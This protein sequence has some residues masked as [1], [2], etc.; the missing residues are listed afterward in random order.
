MRRAGRGYFAVGIYGNKT[1]A[2]L[3]TLWRTA[4]LYEAA[5]V[6]TVRKRYT[7]QCSDTPNTPKHKPLFHFDDIDDLIAHLPQG[8]PLIGVELDPRAIPLPSFGHPLSAAYLL[9]A[10]DNGLPADVVNRCHYLVQIPTPAPWSMNVA[11]AGSIIVNDRHV[12]SQ[13]E[14]GS[15]DEQ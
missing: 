10:E 14:G 6:F 15:A 11:V 4:S 12:K 1:P 9:G 3:G 5:F 8:C 2:N 13:R 7:R